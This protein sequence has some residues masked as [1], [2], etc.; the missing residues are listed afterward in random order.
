MFAH[1]SDF[2]DYLA[3]NLGIPQEMA[4]AMAAEFATTDAWA[5]DAWGQEAAQA[6]WDELIAT[7]QNGTDLTAN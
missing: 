4:E 5:H 7:V 2:I 3:N 1:Q 6:G